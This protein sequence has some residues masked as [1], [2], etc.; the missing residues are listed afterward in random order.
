LVQACA[1]AERITKGAEAGDEWLVIEQICLA[2][3]DPRRLK[4]YGLSAV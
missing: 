2:F 1:K 4:Q 3:C